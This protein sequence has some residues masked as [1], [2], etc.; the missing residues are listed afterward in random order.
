ME[1][2]EGTENQAFQPL[3]EGDLY[4]HWLSA[5]KKRTIQKKGT[6]AKY[7]RKNIGDVTHLEKVPEAIMV[8]AFLRKQKDNI[9]KELRVLGPTTLE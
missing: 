6:V 7:G 2:I 8:G 1:L 5:E 4:E 3:D 9:K